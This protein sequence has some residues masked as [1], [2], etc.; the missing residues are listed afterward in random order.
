MDLPQVPAI[1]ASVIMGLNPLIEGMIA[2]LSGPGG[3]AVLE[4]GE[5]IHKAASPLTPRPSQ[6]IT[7]GRLRTRMRF[8]RATTKAHH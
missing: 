1:A 8:C 6:R 3:I 5:R 7:N 2:R 4:T